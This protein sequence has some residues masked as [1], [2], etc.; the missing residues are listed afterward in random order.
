MEYS[1]PKKIELVNLMLNMFGLSYLED[2]FPNLMKDKGFAEPLRNLKR[3]TFRQMEDILEASAKND[4]LKDDDFLCKMRE[5]F[6]RKG[7]PDEVKKAKELLEKNGY[8][9][10]AI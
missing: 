7:E 1:H 2:N 6:S 10:S 4:I 5:V 9:I 8:K 3:S